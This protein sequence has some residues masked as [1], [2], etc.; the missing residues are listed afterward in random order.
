MLAPEAGL[1]LNQGASARLGVAEGRTLCRLAG[2][3]WITHDGAP[4]DIVIEDG[5]SYHVASRE[6]TAQG[7]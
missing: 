4:K 3:V 1:R 6:R 7:R 2:S 5:D